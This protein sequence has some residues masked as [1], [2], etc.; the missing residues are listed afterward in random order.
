M[1]EWIHGWMNECMF[2]LLSPNIHSLLVSLEIES[3]NFS[4]AYGCPANDHIS[5]PPFQ[6]RYGHV[7]TFWPMECTWKCGVPFIGYALKE[8]SHILHFPFSSCQWLEGGCDGDIWNSCPRPWDGWHLLRMAEQQDLIIHM[9]L[10]MWS[11]YTSPAQLVFKYLSC[12]EHCFAVD[13][14]FGGRWV[15]V[16][17]SESA[18]R[19]TFIESPPFDR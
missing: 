1:N 3:P 18:H 14:C 15:F 4:R 6:A 13:V 8:K 17:P 16:S 5:Q 19:A 7:I 9:F 10:M 2:H 12:L 11:C